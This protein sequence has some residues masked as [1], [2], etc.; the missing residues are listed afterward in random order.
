MK[1]IVIGAAKG[2]QGKTIL[3]Q[4]AN[5]KTLASQVVPTQ[6]VSPKKTSP[7]VAGS[8]SGRRR[9]NFRP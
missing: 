3:A 4:A 6:N 9:P 8:A 2:G 1:L 5:W 7:V